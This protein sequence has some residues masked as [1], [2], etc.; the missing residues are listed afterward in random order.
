[1]RG[2][3]RVREVRHTRAERREALL[4]AAV[5]VIRRAGAAASMDEIASAGGVTKPILYRHFGDREGLLQAVADRFA[6]ELVARLEAS[7]AAVDDLE[8]KLRNTIDAYIAFIQ[9]DPA[10]YAYLGERATISSPVLMGVV[11]RVAALIAREIG[12]QLKSLGADTGAAEPWA[13]AIAGAVHLA[14]ERWVANP[15]MSRKRF[16]DYLVALMWQGM[17]AYAASPGL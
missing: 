16:V 4:T 3:G 12:D 9:E 13:Y 11:D 7:I 6:D 17:P 14:G 5:D 1:M 10:F 2:K 15:T 8:D